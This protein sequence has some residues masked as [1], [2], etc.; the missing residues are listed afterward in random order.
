MAFVPED[1][2]VPRTLVRPELDLE[3]LGPE[4]NE[5]DYAAW[6]SSIEYIRATPGFAGRSWPHDMSLGENRDDLGRHAGDGAIVGCVYIYPGGEGAHVRSWVRADRA[7][8]D[9]VLR[10]AVRDWLASAWPFAEV[11][12]AG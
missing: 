6:S 3:P 1:F 5:G 7:Q 4:H 10:A 9:G 11:E 8:L 12:Y 2:E